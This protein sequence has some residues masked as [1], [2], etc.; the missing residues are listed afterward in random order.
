VVRSAQIQ[1]KER[2]RLLECDD[3]AAVIV[4][5]HR[6]NVFSRGQMFD[7]A[8]ANKVNARGIRDG[9]GALLQARRILAIAPGYTAI[10][11]KSCNALLSNCH[12]RLDGASSKAEKRVVERQRE[13]PRVEQRDALAGFEPTQLGSG[14]SSWNQDFDT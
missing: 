10:R 1:N 5:T 7:G 12:L 11:S 3:V 6:A 8:R 9:S 13:F 14:L 4:E 2:I